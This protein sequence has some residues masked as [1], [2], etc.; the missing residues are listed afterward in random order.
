M[1]DTRPYL[2]VIVTSRNDDHGGNLLKRMQYFVDGWLYQ[3]KKFDLPCEL[4]IVEWNPPPERPPLAEALR[5][6][7]P[8]PCTVRIMEVPRRIHHR[9]KTADRLPL[10]QFIA[11]NAAIRRARGD[12][13]LCTNIDILFSDEMMAFLAARRLRPDRIYRNDRYD[14]PFDIPAGLTIPQILEFC[15]RNVLRVNRRSVTIHLENNSIYPADLWRLDAYAVCVAEVIKSTGIILARLPMVAATAWQVARQPEWQS[16]GE[17]LTAYG[18]ILG[19]LWGKYKMSFAAIRKTLQGAAKTRQLMKVLHTNA[20][21]DFTLMAAEG[22]KKLR[23]HLEFEG[24]SMHLDSLLLMGA[25]Y[26]GVAEEEV[27]PSPMRHYHIEH[28]TGSGFTPENED[29]FYQGLRARGLSWMDWGDILQLSRQILERK[30]PVEF[31]DEN[32]GLGEMPLRET[33]IGPAR[34]THAAE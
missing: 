24:Y 31:N 3:A 18:R 22:W 29:R 25:V 20:C 32:W 16:A 33:V 28:G 8:G 30:V 4:I 5:W 26:S 13:L 21:G 19:T 6:A 34:P 15:A 17:R 2:S 14:V 27:L 11:K 12:Y 10:F 1:T 9:F 23:G 7:D